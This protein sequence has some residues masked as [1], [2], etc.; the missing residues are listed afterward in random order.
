MS[1]HQANPDRVPNRHPD[2]GS[3]ANYNDPQSLQTVISAPRL[4]DET[5]K[6]VLNDGEKLSN[7]RVFPMYTDSGQK[8]GLDADIFWCLHFWAHGDQG[9]LLEFGC[10]HNTVEFSSAEVYHSICALL[11]KRG[12]EPKSVMA[13]DM[14][15]GN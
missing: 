13:T 6:P 9:I 12:Y 11:K 10:P 15:T 14:P 8:T 5:V 2:G 1:T 3:T 4:T 7:A